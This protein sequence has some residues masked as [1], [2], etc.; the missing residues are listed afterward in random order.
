MHAAAVVP[1]ARHTLDGAVRSLLADAL[2]VPTGLLAA[3]FLT[4][5]LGP[6][7]YG[8]LTLAIAITT[9]AEWL[10]LSAFA[11]A[12]IKF[13]G[14]APDWRP[15]GSTALRLHVMA[16]GA[17]GLLLCILAGPIAAFLSEPAL[18]MYLRLF[19]LGIPAVALAAVHREILVG[20]GQFSQSALAT[21]G[22]WISRLVLTVVL[23][24][25]G[26]SVSGAILGVIGA[27]VVEVAVARLYVRPT[28]LNGAAFPAG[29]LWQYA[30]PL[31]L[32]ALSVRVFGSVD[33]LL[34]KALGGTAAQAGIYGGAQNL[35]MLPNFAAVAMSPLL[36]S[37]LS[38]ALRDHGGGA[39]RK[40][41]GMAM[42]AVIGLLPITC[43]I[44]GAAP[45]IVAF[46]FGPQFSP[47]AP[48]LSV[49]IFGVVARATFTV[50]TTILIAAGKPRWT[51]GL[52]APLVPLAIAGHLL[53]IPRFG[54]LGA[55]LVTTVLSTAEA[56]A[57]FIAVYR[58]W[59][60]LPPRATILRSV[61]LCAPAYAAAL[62]WPAPGPLLFVKL[63]LIGLTV[64]LGFFLLGEFSPVELALAR[65]VLSWRTLAP[66][67]PGE[68]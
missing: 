14:E 61:A 20:R 52:T 3:A 27:S 25:L 19:G 18:V 22:R 65:S 9:W 35:A 42:R 57:G 26:L 8:Q 53:A 5:Q 31:F 7:G 12:T 15:V 38:R 29:R 48:L 62:L 17:S 58:L 34:L 56:L 68:I 45:E 32:F 55:S 60:L 2:F 67:P 16:G 64:V 13:V 39:A 59:R 37:T 43:I 46:L 6:E 33:L 21:S 24:E 63:P 36:L 1:R 51:A 11:R 49:L 66:Q 54:P 4:R 23:V 28:W 10:I 41:G 40:V 30:V 50:S 44:V 47:A